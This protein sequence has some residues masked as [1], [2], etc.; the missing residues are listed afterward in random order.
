[1]QNAP[2]PPGGP[3]ALLQLPV[4]LAPSTEQWSLGRIW[5]EFWDHR[6][7]EYRSQ[8]GFYISESLSTMPAL[9][10]RWKN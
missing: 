4:G 7:L 2:S 6:I 3:S 10:Y 5:A 8:K 1:M 9:I